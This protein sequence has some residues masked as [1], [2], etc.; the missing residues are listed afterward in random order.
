MLLDIS[1]VTQTLL[2]LIDK[3][4]TSS[5]EAGKV[6]PLN[7]S[8]LAPDNLTGDRTIGLYLYHITEDAHYKNLPPPSADEPPIRFTPMGL[9]LYYLLTGHS[10]L[11]G[12]TG[13][14]TEQTMVGL[15]MKALRDF[16]VIDDTTTIGALPVFPA[17][18]KG[19][20]NRFR[21]VLQPVQHNEAM[22]YWTAG[23]RA[24]RLGIYY[25]ASVVLL[26]PEKTVSRAGR[27]LT[28]GVYTF[29]R[30]APHLDGSR[31]SV[32]FTSPGE[33]VPRTVEVQPG[34]APITGQVIF[35][36]SELAGDQTTLI[37]KNPRFANPVEVGATWGVVA[38]EGKI[39]ATVQP[40]AGTEKILPGMY[41][42][43]AKVILRRL[44]PDKT[45]R[46]FVTTSNEMPFIVTPRIT[47]ILPPDVSLRVVVQGE[48]FQDPGIAADAVE[49]F[50]GPKKIPFKAA[51]VL[52]AGEF[53]VTN[54]NN[55]RFRYPIAGLISGSVVPF[56]LIIN[57]AESAPNWVTVP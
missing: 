22:N 45:L 1:L 33:A 48:V 12:N 51:A 44:M 50:V 25:Q 16:P 43:I 18:L 5:P 9:N 52:N 20:D 47:S 35:F 36:G 13:V 26:E 30:G 39:L 41:S 40:L 3:H 4:V 17:A 23:S 15:A 7:V 42:A 31:S 27:V 28:Y 49:V 19:T 14:E 32:T 57:G 34:E 6:T 56:R 38:D 2:S 11:A 29:T 53:E 24:L 10:D 8:A 21:I 46:D 55:L 54:P 37:L